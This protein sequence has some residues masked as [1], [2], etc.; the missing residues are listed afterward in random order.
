MFIAVEGIDGSGKGTQCGLLNRWIR[1]KGFETYLTAEPTNGPIG[2]ILREGLKKG[3]LVPETEALL[4]AADR[5]EH[6]K[7]ISRMLEKGRVVITERYLCSSF[8]YQGASGLD[9]KWLKELNRFALLP[10]ITIY[11]DIAPEVAL[12]RI[13]S[14]NS[15]RGR[16]REKEH[17]EKMDILARVREL[18]LGLLESENMVPIDAS[19]TIEDVQAAIRRKVSK[20]LTGLEEKKKRPAQ[21]GLEEYF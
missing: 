20:P 2:R 4:F 14:L 7:E 12:K 19:G 16:M 10:D 21:K 6:I 1:E 13:S 17:F 9:M 11:L 5:S 3:G 8:A 18:Y 15:L